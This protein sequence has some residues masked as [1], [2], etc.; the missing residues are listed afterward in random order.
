MIKSILIWCV[1]VSFGYAEFLRDNTNNI[2]LDTKTNLVWQDDANASSVTK[3]WVTQANY[4]DGN[5]SDTSGDTAIMY[6]EDLNLSGYEDWRLPN[7]KELLSIVDKSRYNP[8]VKSVFQNISSGYYWS[9]S[10][11]TNFSNSAWYVYFGSGGSDDDGKDDSLY[12]RCVR[13]GQ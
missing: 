6:C 12:V 13:D 10:T 1:V 3:K 2:V 8:A 5:Y 11:R 4:D 9:S 7:I